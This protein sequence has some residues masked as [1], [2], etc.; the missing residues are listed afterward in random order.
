MRK[1]LFS[2][3]TLL[4]GLCILPLL[5]CERTI[6][7]VDSSQK[8]DYLQGNTTA[9]VILKLF[10]LYSNSPLSGVKVVVAGVDSAKTD[11]AGT[12]VF[13]SV[14]AGNYLVNC[15]KSGFE[16]SQELLKLSI[17]SNSTTVPIV[18]QSTGVFYMARRGVT[19]SG[20]LYFE[21][22]NTVSHADEARIECRV[23]NRAISFQS[24]VKITTSDEGIYSFED[25]PEF[26]TYTI[27]VR[28]F[29]DG[30]LFFK[31]A[32]TVTANGMM[33]DDLVRADDIILQEFT[34]GFFIAMDHNLEKLEKNDS[35]EIDFSEAVD[36]HKLSEDSI[37]V[38]TNTGGKRILIQRIWKNDN[39]TLVIVPYDGSWDPG[40]IYM[41]TIGTLESVTGKPLDN[42][43]FMAYSFTAMSSGTLDDV[44]NFRYH[45][46]N[47]DTVKADYNTTSITLLW[48]K[49]EN[50]VVYQIY[51][52]AT[53]D[54]SWYLAATT[55]DTTRTVTTTEGFNEDNQI[56]FLVLG[57][58]SDGVSNFKDAEILTVK[59]E[60][61]PVISVTSGFSVSGC[62]NTGRT[63]FDTIRF[64]ISASYISEPLDTTGTPEFSV[65]E[66]GYLSGSTLYGDTLYTVDSENCYWTW[67]TQRSGAIHIVV[68]ADENGAY[69]TL[70]VDFTSLT[71]LAGNEVDTED[72]RGSISIFLR[73]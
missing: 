44:E 20:N 55:A 38:E 70:N 41:L 62:N 34:D 18:N 52:K 10:D 59:D 73:P 49:L 50:A 72:D 25:L 16:S 14:M 61:S 30:S 40:E 58:N 37:Y 51:Q 23:T 63:V 9:R 4:L 32:E 26:S 3:F 33:Y 28:L 21:K 46:G 36:T 24:P 60:T 65:S 68:D 1:P 15:S 64:N 67:T 13:D 12:V 35:I 22:E 47:S 6:L 54:S 8:I 39:K 71:D 19:L 45:A 42:T 27:T 66:G 17:D 43:N 2:I 11:S 29:K 5:N 53:S 69:D 7:P 56:Q 31:Q 57:K 48:T